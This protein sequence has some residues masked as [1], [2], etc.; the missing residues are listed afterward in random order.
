MKKILKV[1]TSRNKKDLYFGQKIIL[2]ERVA[3]EI[4]AVKANLSNL[5]V[6]FG[7]H[8]PQRPSIRGQRFT[9]TFCHAANTD[10]HGLIK[11]LD[12]DLKSR[13]FYIYK[14]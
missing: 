3:K 10:S 7:V 14:M 8:I 6:Q 11:A 13:L 1:L 4:A 9:I 12:A 5:V 2:R